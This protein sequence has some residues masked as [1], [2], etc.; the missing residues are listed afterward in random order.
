[1]SSFE[2]SVDPG[3]CRQLA[4]WASRLATTPGDGDPE[5]L[6]PRFRD[7]TSQLTAAAV[8]GEGFAKITEMRLC[9][10]SR[11]VLHPDQL[12][13]FTIAPGCQLCE[14]EAG[15]TPRVLCGHKILDTPDELLLTAR[16]FSNGN[17]RKADVAAAAYRLAAA[18]L[19]SWGV[20]QHAKDLESAAEQ[21]ERGLASEWTERTP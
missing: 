1:M 8:L 5:N 21:A 9:E 6:R 17:A 4:D 12:Y 16:E 20:E 3:L 19:R 15:I 10:A 11:V 7:I 13:R 18:K 14:V 2:H